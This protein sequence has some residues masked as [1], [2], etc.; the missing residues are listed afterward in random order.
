MSLRQVIQLQTSRRLPQKLPSTGRGRRQRK[1]PR[2]CPACPATTP[3][4]ASAKHAS[5]VESPCLLHRPR[6]EHERGKVGMV[7]LL[8]CKCM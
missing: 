6:I 1:L 8:G 3:G 2:C 4:T 5:D 7:I